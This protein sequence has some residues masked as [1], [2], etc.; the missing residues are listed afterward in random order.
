MTDWVN[1]QKH[2][3]HLYPYSNTEFSSFFA[4]GIFQVKFYISESGKTFT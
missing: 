3:I 4:N 1:F 2:L